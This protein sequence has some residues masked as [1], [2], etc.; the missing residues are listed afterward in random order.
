MSY[1]VIENINKSNFLQVFDL[2]PQI[3]LE[4]RF[5]LVTKR[6]LSGHPATRACKIPTDDITRARMSHIVSE[7]IRPPGK[8]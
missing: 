4:L 1:I 8:S 5:V 2:W 6:A 3:I 7:N